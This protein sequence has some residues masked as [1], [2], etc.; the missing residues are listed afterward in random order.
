MALKTRKNLIPSDN[1]YQMKIGF[2]LDKVLID[3]PPLVSPKII[4]KLYKKKDNGTLLYKIP[5]YPEQVIR[6]LSHI[7][8]LRQPIKRNMTFLKSIS[9]KR[10]K[11]YLISSRFNFLKSRT[12]KLM[13]KNGLDKI[14]D[15]AFFNFK[16]DQPHIFKSTIIKKLKLDRY[17]D[18]DL[19]LLKHAARNN[20]DTNFFWLNDLG[21]NK[22]ISNN[23]TAISEI[24]LMLDDI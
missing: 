11:L 19:S 21:Q 24:E 6:R 22:K 3:Y 4:D 23:I 7:T 12:E 13:K 16:N 17:V 10:N 20:P 14:F 8:P 5:G 9:K 2:D 18:D 1:Y 15:A